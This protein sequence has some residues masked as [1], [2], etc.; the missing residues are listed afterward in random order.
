VR[1]GVALPKGLHD[2]EGIGDARAREPIHLEDEHFTN[3]AGADVGEQAPQLDAVRRL[4]RGLLAV[5]AR[6]GAA[7]EDGVADD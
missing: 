5:P 2:P 1:R 3:D 6:R 7:L 4:G